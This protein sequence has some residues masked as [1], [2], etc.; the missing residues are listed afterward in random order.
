MYY[1][2]AC[3][4]VHITRTFKVNGNS[5]IIIMTLYFKRLQTLGNRDSDPDKFD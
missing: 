4:F 3:P 2:Y 1:A 5:R